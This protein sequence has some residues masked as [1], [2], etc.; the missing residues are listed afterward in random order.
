MKYQQKQKYTKRKKEI[1]FFEHDEPEEHSIHLTKLLK[2]YEEKHPGILFAKQKMEN[3]Y[4]SLLLLQ[5]GLDPVYPLV[6]ERLGAVDIEKICMSLADCQYRSEISDITHPGIDCDFI[7]N[8]LKG[9]LPEFKD[10]SEYHLD[11]VTINGCAL[12]VLDSDFETR[13]VVFDSV[14]VDNNAPKIEL[15]EPQLNKVK[16]E[17]S[18]PNALVC[19]YMIFVMVIL[20]MAVMLRC[21][22]NTTRKNS[23]YGVKVV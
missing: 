7:H 4:Y 15:S 3:G 16:V 5:Y 6:V 22:E 20:M 21:C 14:D 13:K 12:K 9:D 2:D 8:F 10:I 1:I 11:N 19:I 17:F 23:I 18:D